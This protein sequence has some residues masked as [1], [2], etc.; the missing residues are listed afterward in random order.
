MTSSSYLCENSWTPLP[1]T[2]RKW[3]S[4]PKSANS[5]TL[6]TSIPKLEPVENKGD[7]A[8]NPVYTDVKS[9]MERP[10]PTRLSQDHVWGMRD[11]W[12]K[13]ANPWGSGVQAFKSQSIG[14]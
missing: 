1:Q 3:E 4:A 8:T 10:A 11:D 14:T 2:S 12:G 6:Q 9:F 7:P 5:S 13:G